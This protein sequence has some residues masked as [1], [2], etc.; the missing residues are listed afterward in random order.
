[1]DKTQQKT[2]NY[3]WIAKI[4]LDILVYAWITTFVCAAFEVAVWIGCAA[5]VLLTVIHYKVLPASL[6]SWLFCSQ[7][8]QLSDNDYIKILA[9]T[10][11]TLFL[12][13]TFF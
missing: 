2:K 10:I 1:M 9:G 13:V 4:P 6:G 7:K 3:R 8:E 5:A 12:L 11:A